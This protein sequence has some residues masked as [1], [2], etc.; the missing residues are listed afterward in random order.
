MRAKYRRPVI[1]SYG[2]ETFPTDTSAGTHTST[3]TPASPTLSV[4]PADT[5]TTPPGFCGEGTALGEAIAGGWV[6]ATRTETGGD[7]PA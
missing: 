2:M 6:S 4:T 3:H 7:T 5:F 1:G